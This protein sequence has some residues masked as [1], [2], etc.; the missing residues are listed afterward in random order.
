MV[1]MKVHWT[2]DLSFAK[3]SIVTVDEGMAP[4]DRWPQCP[5][6]SLS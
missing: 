3:N 1:A 2:I 4:S 6:Y 5:S